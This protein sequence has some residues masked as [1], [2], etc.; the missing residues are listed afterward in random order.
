[1][2]YA[3]IAVV[4]VLVIFVVVSYF[5]M[6]KTYKFQIE[7]KTIIVKN[8]G[9]NLKVLDND[10]LISASCYPDLLKGDTLEFKIGENNYTLKCKSSALGYKIRME[11]YKDDKMICDNGVVLKK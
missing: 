4:C 7:D 5:L 1:M 3:L 2:L 11:I 10:K 6:K 9:S 8:A